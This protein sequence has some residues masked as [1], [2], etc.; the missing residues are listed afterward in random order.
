MRP[1]ILNPAKLAS[2]FRAELELCNVRPGE[3]IAL[4]SDLEWPNTQGGGTRTTKGHY[5]VPMRDCTVML[6]GQVII[7]RG[8]VVDPKMIVPRVTR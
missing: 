6:D 7:E 4:L 3:T 2:L 5:D 1:Q 8:R